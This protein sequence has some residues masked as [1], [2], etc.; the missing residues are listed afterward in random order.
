MV[1]TI[2]TLGNQLG[3]IWAFF[4][5]EETGDLTLLASLLLAALAL[6]TAARCVR[7][8]QPAFGDKE[9]GSVVA[10][11]GAIAAVFGSVGLYFLYLAI[12]A[13]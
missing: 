3:M 6:A 8:I 2:E 4:E 5:N 13:I 11:G 12:A 1:E 7:V 9:L 10:V